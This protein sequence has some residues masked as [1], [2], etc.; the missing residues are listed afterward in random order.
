MTAIPILEVKKISKRFDNIMAVNNI[1][2]Q[3]KPGICFGLLGPNGAGKTTTIEMIEGILKPTSGEILYRGI[4]QHHI[5]KQFKAETGIQFQNTLLQEFLTVKEN[6]Y[7]FK[8]FY[9]KGLEIDEL[10]T[11]CYLNDFLDKDT[12]KI[13]G[14]QKQRLLLALALI[15]DPTLLILDE[16]TVG[17]DPQARRNFWELI[18]NIKQRNKTIILTTHYMEE[19]DLLCDEIVIIDKGQIIIQG[20]PYLLTKEAAE[21]QSVL[22]PKHAFEKT[23]I[24]NQFSIQEENGHIRILTTDLEETLSALLYHGVS[25]K[26]L[27][28]KAPNLEDL[29]LKLTGHRLRE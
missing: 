9:N 8:S 19:A 1:S 10:I 3:I 24:L 20:A 14:G 29:F 23:N 2:F 13:S 11:L 7:L 18:Q 22:L 21:T 17:L 27:S 25:L 4:P 15:N 28:I 6:L 26:D 16:P 5:K 12:R